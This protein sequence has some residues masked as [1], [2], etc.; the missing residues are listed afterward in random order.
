MPNPAL[1]SAELISMKQSRTLTSVVLWLSSITWPSAW[2]C[3]VIGMWRQSSHM[4]RLWRSV[5]CL[6]SCTSRKSLSTVSRTSPPSFR[7]ACLS[8]V[9]SSTTTRCLLRLDFCWKHILK[10]QAFCGERGCKHFWVS[11]L[12][13]YT[14]RIGPCVLRSFCLCI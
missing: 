10:Q 2:L 1:I 9:W 12:G 7:W 6:G 4:E 14:Y 5:V 11:Y 3:D 8:S 13:R